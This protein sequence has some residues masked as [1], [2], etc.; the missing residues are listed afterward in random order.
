[1][2]VA[3]GH[4]TGYARAVT[5]ED[6]EKLEKEGYHANSVIGKSGLEQVYEKQLRPI[7]GIQS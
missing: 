7:D 3:A 1:M 5:A 6:L 4:L 2:G